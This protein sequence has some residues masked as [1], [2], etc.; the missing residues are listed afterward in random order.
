MTAFAKDIGPLASPDRLL[1]TRL[2]ATTERILSAVASQHQWVSAAILASQTLLPMAAVLG[3]L[4][5]L[6]RAGLIKIR[7]HDGS[8]SIQAATVADAR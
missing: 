1:S 2:D 5:E 6:Q 3:S 4:V 8:Q 7:S